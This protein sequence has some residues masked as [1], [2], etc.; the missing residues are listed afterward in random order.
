MSWSEAERLEV[1]ET[2]REVGPDAPT[3]C[4]GW[5]SRHLLAH[6]VLREQ[7]PWA[8]VVDGASRR[9][10]GQEPVLGATAESAATPEGYAALLERFAAGPGRLS[11]VGWMGDRANLVEYVVHHEDVRRAG[12]TPAEP[13]VLEAPVVREVWRHLTPMAKLAARR[14]PVGVVLVVPGGPRAVVR[15]RPDAVALTGDPVE[16]ALYLMGRTEVAEV[17]FDGLP[18]VVERFRATFEGDSA[19]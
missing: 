16:L 3:L 1:V 13:R 4:E 9:E 14:S 18:D 8:M 19:A 5:R 6:L 12:D 7:R 2:F 11:P 15:R 17:E 10:P